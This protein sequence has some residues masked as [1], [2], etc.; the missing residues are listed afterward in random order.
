MRKIFAV[1]W[2]FIPIC[3]IAQ[4]FTKNEILRFKNE[5]KAV[6]IIRDNWGIPHIYGKTDANA[7][8]GLMYAQCEEN[9]KGLERNYLYQLGR[10]SE[11]DGEDKLYTDVQLQLIA[12]SAGA[13]KDYKSSPLWF[14]KLT[15]AFADGINYYL[16]KHPE[17]KPAVFHHFEPWYALMFT[18]G[19]VSATQTGGI[20]IKETRDFYSNGPESLGNASS[21]HTTENII[22]E[23]ETGSNGFALAP[24]LTASRHA[25]LYITSFSTFPRPICL[26]SS[27]NG[28]SGY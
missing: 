7:V 17:V 14:K 25:M 12:D 5:A 28:S 13:I 8:F 21:T 19:S 3:C 27:E 20:N 2:L 1:I 11:V 18:D 15:N 23:R 10:Q 22:T 6:T 4:S 26:E 16:Y 9:F 24:S